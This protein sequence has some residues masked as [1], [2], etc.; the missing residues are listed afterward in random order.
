MSN[1]L[2]RFRVIDSR[3]KAKTKRNL[4]EEAV[5]TVMNTRARYS[6]RAAG[7]GTLVAIMLFNF[8]QNQVLV[9]QE[10]CLVL[11]IPVDSDSIIRDPEGVLAGA[12]MDHKIEHLGTKQVRY[13]LK[14]QT[15]CDKQV[16]RRDEL[17]PGRVCPKADVTMQQRGRQRKA[18][19]HRNQG[20]E[21]WCK[22]ASTG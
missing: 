18:V 16:G 22:A 9:L 17:V 14:H 1:A 3:K 12:G 19:R 13:Q 5:A 11:W 20:R 4:R 6:T 8:M 7:A 21:R 15:N 2:S 10:H